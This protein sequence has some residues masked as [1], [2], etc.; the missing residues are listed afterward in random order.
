[1][2][3]KLQDSLILNTKVMSNLSNPG[4]FTIAINAILDRTTH[5]VNCNIQSNP[6]FITEWRKRLHELQQCKLSSSV[7]FL[8]KDASYNITD[9]TLIRKCNELITKY[10]N[11]KLLFTAS[12][13]DIVQAVDIA[14]TNKD[15]ADRLGVSADVL[16]EGLQ[17]TIRTYIKTGE[18]LQAIDAALQ[19]KLN[20]IDATISCMNILT[21]LDQT[22]TLHILAGPVEDYLKSVFEKNM[23][24]STYNAY[25]ETYK[26]FI[27]LRSIIEVAN[28]HKPTGPSCTICMT[29][30]VSYAIAPCGHTFCEDCS[31]KQ[32]TSC[33]VCRTQIR[34]RL[35]I[36]Y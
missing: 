4:D 33:Y 12:S 36:Y 19:E 10:A 35:R 30:E 14:T 29:K 23:I 20:H 6:Q 25:I 11:P 7:A 31:A 8:L 28:I 2:R 15:I 9:H 34:D 27:S 5:T 17:K 3:S 22:E 1:M 32:M 16:R 24:E 13:S 18:E 26:R 21:S